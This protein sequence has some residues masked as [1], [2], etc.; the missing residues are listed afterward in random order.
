M[1][2]DSLLQQYESGRLT[3]RKLPGALATLVVVP[4]AAAAAGVGQGAPVGAVKSMNHANIFV[5]SVQ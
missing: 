3:P 4:A 5:P 2:L 1:N